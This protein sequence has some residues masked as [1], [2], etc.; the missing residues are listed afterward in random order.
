[1]STKKSSGTATVRISITEV[2]QDLNFETPLSAA[3]VKA[4]V[5]EALASGNPLILSD[6]KGREIIVPASK[7]GC[8]DI[9]QAQERR[10]G[11]G[12]L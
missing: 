7:I 1:M 9:G 3:E 2:A 12:A 5:T 10:V 8:V 4:A 11:F 6:V